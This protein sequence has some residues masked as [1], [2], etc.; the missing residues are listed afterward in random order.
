MI[1]F[2]EAEKKLIQETG[3]DSD[4]L[5]MGSDIWEKGRE[6]FRCHRTAEKIP[7]KDE[8]GR[9]ICYAFQDMDANRELRMLEELCEEKAALHFEDIYPEYDCVVIQECNELAYSFA[10]YLKGRGIPVRV[11]GRYWDKIGKW[12]EGEAEGRVLTIYAEGTWEHNHN[13][14]YELLRS[15][16]VEFEY[17]DDLYKENIRR[18]IIKNSKCSYRELIEKLR[19]KEVILI[20][21]GNTAQDVYDML[22]A[23]GLDIAAFLSYGAKN[24]LKLLGKEIISIEEIGKYDSPVFIELGKNSALGQGHLEE[25]IYYGC[26]RNE[27]YFFFGDYAEIE[28]NNLQHVLQGKRILLVGERLLA[29][30]LKKYMLNEG[31]EADSV[32][33]YEE[34]EDSFIND[35]AVGVVVTLQMFGQINGFANWKNEID[36]CLQTLKKHKIENYTL[37]FTMSS[38]FA[39]IE[40]NKEKY[41]SNELRPK[42]ILLGAINE[43]SGNVFFRD[44]IDDH[45]NIIQFG[46]TPFENDMLWYCI[47]CSQVPVGEVV[48][49]LFSMYKCAYG[50]EGVLI[51]FPNPDVFREKCEALLKGKETVTPQEL[52]VIFA[53]AYNEMIG[54]KIQNMNQTYIYWEPHMQ[55]VPLRLLY[56]DWLADEKTKGVA[57]YLTRDSL[58]SAGSG[59]TYRYRTNQKSGLVQ[60]MN[61]LLHVPSI[62]DMKDRLCEYIVLK[63]EELKL[64][65]R[66][67]WQKLCDILEISWSDTF[68]NTTRFG[69]TS[70]FYNGNNKITGY[71]LGPVYRDYADLFS[72]FDKMRICFCKAEY[73]RKYGYSYDNTPFTRKE[74]QELYLREFKCQKVL[75]VNVEEDETEYILAH[76]YIQRRLNEIYVDAFWDSF[77]EKDA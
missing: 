10:K 31:K 53:I 8:N 66:E 50:E 76:K 16:S 77:T 11:S 56:A 17:I 25:N 21:T 32:Q 15:V 24:G 63:F 29:S 69:K 52:F 49:T 41:T 70:Y 35:D 26:K 5:I 44:C 22:V 9:I 3:K 75:E 39:R 13:L 7:V 51:I 67:T 36:L 57:V 58:I 43:C 40:L 64:F 18:G 4:Y 42:G 65:P 14:S 23:E 54:R 20:G 19:S 33:Y 6:W 55:D 48:S 34:A 38:S 37:Y 74:L 59:L 2:L 46:Y 45:P 28:R 12:E 47:Y 60:M 71:D 62:L 27:D 30:Y 61:A 1:R 72:P 73:Q 68:L